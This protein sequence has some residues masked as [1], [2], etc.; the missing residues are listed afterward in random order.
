M[1][2][3]ILFPERK[4]AREMAVL[5]QE[6]L[7]FEKDTQHIFACQEDALFDAWRLVS[8]GRELDS[9]EGYVVRVFFESMPSLGI[10]CHPD[11]VKSLHLPETEMLDS[12]PVALH[13]FAQNQIVIPAE[14]PQKILNIL[15]LRP[16]Q[17]EL[18]VGRP[19]VWGV[20]PKHLRRPEQDSI[21]LL[22]R[23]LLES[24]QEWCYTSRL[25]YV[26]FRWIDR[27]E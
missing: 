3:E 25:Q 11:H 7:R 10:I 23:G 15:S 2:L 26:I 19:F 13:V 9:L 8:T 27:S 1:V 14:L 16:T 24:N 4:H 18:T 6:R 22:Q 21:F 5:K 12:S 20:Y 17:E